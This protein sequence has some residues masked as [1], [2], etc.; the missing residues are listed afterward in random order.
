MSKMNAVVHFEMPAEDKKR[1]AEFYTKVFGWRTQFLGADMGE[2]VVVNTSETDD[3]GRP[4]NPGTINGGFYQKTNDPHSNSPSIVISV[5]NINESIRSIKKAGGTVLGEPMEIPGIGLYASFSDT[6]GNR[7]S[8]L[9]P[10][11]QMPV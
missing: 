7:V 9:Q 6:E 2:Y 10:S 8:V 1:M 4:K 5:D 11:A 3:N